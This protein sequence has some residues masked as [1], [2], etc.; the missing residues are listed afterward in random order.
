[1]FVAG[2]VRWN[3]EVTL[4]HLHALNG[5][6]KEW[7]NRGASKSKKSTQ[8]R[9][10]DMNFLKCF[11]VLILL[12]NSSMAKKHKEV[13]Y[14]AYDGPARPLDQV[15]VVNFDS[16]SKFPLRLLTVDNYSTGKKWDH[17]SLSE[18]CEIKYLK[19]KEK[20]AKGRPPLPLVVCKH[21]PNSI[22]LP[23]GSHT[24]IVNVLHTEGWSGQH[25][26]GL[27]GFAPRFTVEAGKK[28]YVQSHFAGTTNTSFVGS[29]ITAYTVGEWSVVVN[30][31]TP[32]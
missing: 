19:A 24:F 21:W 17:Q 6:L 12:T 25:C 18:G 5:G 14:Q 28:Y 7:R 23:P 16:T 1:M 27:C 8:E 20:E 9:R 26:S 11:A 31:M 30:E 3:Q 22:Q 4:G 2:G 10:I 13:S 15:A 32:K 29:R